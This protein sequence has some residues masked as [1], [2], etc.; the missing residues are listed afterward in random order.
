MPDASISI[1]KWTRVMDY[2]NK[3]NGCTSSEISRHEGT[4]F[5]YV[6]K[7]IDK[8]KEKGFLE[9]KKSG[10]KVIITMTESGEELG[11]LSTGIIQLLYPKKQRKNAKL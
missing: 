6:H 7:L 2:I 3:H 4:N 11:A 5:G 10:R 9:T 8:L 1:E